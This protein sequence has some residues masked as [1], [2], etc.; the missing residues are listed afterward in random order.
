MQQSAPAAACT[1]RQGKNP[2]RACTPGIQYGMAKPSGSFPRPV[3]PASCPI[4]LDNSF[5]TFTAVGRAAYVN[6]RRSLLLL[7]QSVPRKCER[8][9]AFLFFFVRFVDRCLPVRSARVS[10][11]S[12]KRGSGFAAAVVPI[13]S[14]SAVSLWRLQKY[15]ERERELAYLT[16][17]FSM[18]S[19]IS[20]VLIYACK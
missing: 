11:L 4:G 9:S 15:A 3:F 12:R 20:Q 2:G 13:P 17:H 1:S 10:V 7:H 19:E 8:L 14:C 6:Q 16:S 5:A 18:C